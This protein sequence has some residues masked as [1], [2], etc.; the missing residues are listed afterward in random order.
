MLKRTGIV[1]IL[2]AALLLINGVPSSAEAADI[3][4]GPSVTIGADEI[5]DDDVYAS[6]GIV[7]VKGTINGDLVAGAGNITVDGNINGDVIAGGGNIIITGPVSDDIR[8]GGGQ[9]TIAT[10]VGGDVVAGGGT[11]LLTGDVAGDLITGTGT[12]E[13]NGT[14]DGDAK[15]GAGEAIINGTIRGNVQADVDSRLTLGPTGRI[16]GSLNYRSRQAVKLADG[17]EILGQTTHEVP[18]T[19]VLGVSLRDSILTNILKSVVSRV[20]WFI[21]ISVVGLLL[22]WIFPQLARRVADTPMDSPWKCLG[23]SLATLLLVPILAIILGV[24]ALVIAGISAIP[25][26]LVP[27]AIYLVLLSLTFPIMSLSIGTLILRRFRSGQPVSGWKAVLIG[28]AVLAVLGLIPVVSILTNI[29]VVLFGF[30]AWVLF[31]YRQH[32]RSISE[33]QPVAASG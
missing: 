17:A 13:M 23:L 24:I 10:T 1:L 21:G 5:I 15:I 28:A 3:L 25:M 8:V 7:V 6:G 11:L 32:A 9:I 30:G 26:L 16:E 12:L 29:L 4:T 27:G 19:K 31:L 33:V 18:D 20:R 22:L 14:V 2:C